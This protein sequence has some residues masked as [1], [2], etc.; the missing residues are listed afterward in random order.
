MTLALL[1]TAQHV[2]DVNTSIFRSLRLLVGCCVGWLEACWCYV[3]GLSVGD[4]VS[5]CRLNQ[6]TIPLHNTNTP[7][8]S[9]HNNAPSSFKLLKMD[10]LT[11][12]T[13]WAVNW[14]NKAS[15]IKLVYLYSNIKRT[16][17]YCSISLKTKNWYGHENPKWSLISPPNQQSVH[18]VPTPLSKHRHNSF[19]QTSVL[20]CRYVQPDWTRLH[21]LGC[22]TL[23]L[24]AIWFFE[25][26]GTAA[27]QHFITSQKIWFFSN[28]AV[29]ATNLACCYV[30]VWCRTGCLG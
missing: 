12:E 3:A 11:S 15:V 9:L 28:T 14:H 13:C 25:T 29:G 17:P 10:V 20:V 6:Q 8:V 22:M 4:V 30:F 24:K 21:F 18:R 23:K 2:S 5:E 27:Q 19:T 7:Q 26:P 1:S 16:E